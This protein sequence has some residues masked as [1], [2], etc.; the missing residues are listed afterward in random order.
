MLARSERGA[1]RTT[2]RVVAAAGG[3]LARVPRRG[4]S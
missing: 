2:Q 3:A 1:D 4:Y